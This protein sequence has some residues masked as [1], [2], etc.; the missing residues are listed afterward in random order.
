MIT[1]KPDGINEISCND[2]LF[3][4]DVFSNMNSMSRND[5]LKKI[6]YSAFQLISEAEKGSFYELQHEKFV[7]IFSEGYDLNVI[8]KLSFSREETYIGYEGPISAD[9]EV[10]EI[11]FEKRDE[12]KFNI[13]TIKT[14]KE[15]GTYSNFTSLYAPIQVNGLNVGLISIE[16]FSKE[17]FSETSKKILKFYAQIISNFY[18]QRVYLEQEKKM[19]NEIVSALISAI[20]VN[21]KYTEGHA[22]RVRKYSCAIAKKLKLPWELVENISTA[23]LL[24]DIGKIGVPTEILNKTGKLT[25]EEY[26]II[27]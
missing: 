9:V 13:E 16:R 22:Q 1:M 3:A 14:F 8:K 25:L 26:N 11:Y 27:K 18:I 6:F 4:M 19:Y 10:K 15:L 5:F 20:E 23:A 2:I 17:G 24:H 12:S 21:D 7:P